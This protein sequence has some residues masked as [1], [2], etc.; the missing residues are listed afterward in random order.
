MV[1]GVVKRKDNKVYD[2][3]LIIGGGDMIIANYLLENFS[4]IVKSITICEIDERVIEVV[5]QY[6]FNSKTINDSIATGKLKIINE[7][8][9]VYTKT[10]VDKN[11]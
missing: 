4:D 9:C 3:I 11:E 6:F 2:H 7:D 8:G 5:K 1:E 10:L